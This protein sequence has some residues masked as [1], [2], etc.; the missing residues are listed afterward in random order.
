MVTSEK[1]LTSEKLK[2]INKPEFKMSKYPFMEFLRVHQS[3]ATTHFSAKYLPVIRVQ[4]LEYTLAASQLFVNQVV[5]VMSYFSST[6][7]LGR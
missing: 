4:G 2:K 6:W 3:E 7:R 1:L 5:A